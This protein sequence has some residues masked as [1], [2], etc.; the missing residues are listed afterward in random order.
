MK[1]L[2]HTASLALIASSAASVHGASITPRDG[3]TPPG[4]GMNVFYDVDIHNTDQFP[5]PEWPNS[6]NAFAAFKAAHAGVG[7]IPDTVDFSQVDD[8][9]PDGGYA[10]LPWGE[11][12]SDNLGHPAV[13]PK[14]YFREGVTAQFSSAAP[15]AFPFGGIVRRF[16]SDTT[17][18]PPP[19]NPEGR[20]P[21]SGE[22]YLST[23][24]TI[25][26]IDFNQPVR[27]FGFFGIDVGDFGATLTITL[28]NGE[29]KEF[30]IPPLSDD[31]EATGSVMFWGIIAD[32][33][34]TN[35]RFSSDVLP[36]VG[37]SFAFDQFTIGIIPLPNA[38][39]L[40]TM[41]LVCLTGASAFRRRRIS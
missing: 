7:L 31:G 12:G 26:Q 6:D 2:L 21:T 17:D 34:F 3:T 11:S 5:L 39:G 22:Q 4:F 9:H 23:G 32:Q 30:K 29:E 37:D 24:T 15:A 14:V 13:D 28:A 40:G 16:E 36:V 18:P 41:G 33:M 38:F 10:N 27:T 35:V 19:A 20:Y 8:R 25:L 1:T